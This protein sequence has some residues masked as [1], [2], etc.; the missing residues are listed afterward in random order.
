MICDYFVTVLVYV[1]CSHIHLFS[2]WMQVCS[3]NQSI[4]SSMFSVQCKY[5]AIIGLIWF[6]YMLTIRS[7]TILQSVWAKQQQPVLVLFSSR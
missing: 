6:N 3:I 7:S 5:V 1:I 4:Q 2:F